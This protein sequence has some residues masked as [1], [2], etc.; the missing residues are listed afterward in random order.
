MNTDK[1][2]ALFKYLKDVSTNRQF[3]IYV[4]KI[5]TE[6]RITEHCKRWNKVKQKQIFK[7]GDIVKYH[8]QVQPKSETGE[9]KKLS[10][11]VR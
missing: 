3:T 11:Q 2:Q 8:I 7:V 5:L 10:H 6:E 4:L 1:N 9:A